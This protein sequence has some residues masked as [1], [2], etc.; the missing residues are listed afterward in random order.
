[1]YLDK[2]NTIYIHPL[3]TGGTFIENNLINYSYERKTLI[4]GFSD[5][6]NV[7]GLGGQN[8]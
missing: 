4:E 1:M 7:F 6:Q 5:H 2:L 8:T 3:K